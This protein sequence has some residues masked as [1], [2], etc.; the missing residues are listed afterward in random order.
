MCNGYELWMMKG[1]GVD[2][3]RYFLGNRYVLFLKVNV[4]C[5]CYEKCTW[6]WVI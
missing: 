4:F 2:R 6:I 3:F 1:W 5:D